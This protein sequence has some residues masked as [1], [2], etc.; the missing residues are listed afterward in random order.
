VP[1]TIAHGRM[2]SIQTHRRADRLAQQTELRSPPLLR[3]LR[4][5]Y[6]ARC[7]SSPAV[8]SALVRQVR[9]GVVHGVFA[10]L[11]LC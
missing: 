9:D 10:V 4:G 3:P 1:V 11:L 2:R 5:P 6:L 8:F 7:R